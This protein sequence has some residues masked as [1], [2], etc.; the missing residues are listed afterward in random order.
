MSDENENEVPKDLGDFIK[1]VFGSE[2]AA[3]EFARS[4][5]DPMIEAWKGLY[6]IYTG[7]RLGGFTPTQADGVMGAYL[8]RLVTGLGEGQ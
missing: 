6:E 4:L 5:E 8:Y 3:E 7:L 1:N 2:S